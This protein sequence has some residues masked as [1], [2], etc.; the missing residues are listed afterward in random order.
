MIAIKARISIPDPDFTSVAPIIVPDLAEVLQV[1]YQRHREGKYWKGEVFGWEAEYNP[2][3]AEPPLDSKTTFTPADFCIG[4]SGIWF[5]SMIQEHGYHQPLVEFLGDLNFLAI[6][7]WVALF[8]RY[9]IY[10]PLYESRAT[11]LRR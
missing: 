10:L 11:F 3:R 9:V 7:A 6:I 8:V 4:E 2:E 1:A 5:F